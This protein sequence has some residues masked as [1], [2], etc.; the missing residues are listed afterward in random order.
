MESEKYHLQLSENLFKLL[1]TNRPLA[2]KKFQELPDSEQIDL[3]NNSSNKLARE[4]LFLSKDARVIL[5]EIKNQK[6]GELSLQE[7]LED[8]LVIISNCTSEQFAYLLDIDLWRK[9]KID[10]KRFLEWIEIIK[11]IPGSQF[12]NI[13]KNLDVNAL[14]TALSSYVQ[15][16]LNTEDLLLMHHLGSEHIYSMHDLDIDNAEIEAFIHYILVADPDYY[17]Q[18]IKVLATEDIEEIM[19]EAKGGRDDRISEQKLPSYEESLIINTF[20]EHFDFSPLDN[21]V[22]TSNTKEVILSEETN[23]DQT[24]LEH[25]RKSDDYINHHKKKLEFKLNKQLA[26]LTNCVIILDG[27]SP[28]DEFQYREGIKKSQSI[29]N[30]GLAYLANQ[31]IPEGINIIIEKTAIEIYQTGYTLLSYIQSRASNLLD[32]DDEVIARF[33]KQMASK[34]RFMDQDFPMIYSEL[35]KKGRR[36]N[37]LAELLILHNDLNSLEEFKSDI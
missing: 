22:I 36:I 1:K 26:H 29:F 5:K 28:T 32:E 11:E 2:E 16:H 31:S 15:I 6:F 25:I 19:N 27:L 12:R 23:R 30:I 4:I 24:F 17:N 34:L 35:S 8:S 14:S 21:L 20:I 18:L 9:G 3:I 13:T 7:Y 33:S 37:S 10:S